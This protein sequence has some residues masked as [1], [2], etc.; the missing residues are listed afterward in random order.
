MKYLGVRVDQYLNWEGHLLTRW[1]K[2]NIHPYHL[3]NL[4]PLFSLNIF[5]ARTLSDMSLGMPVT[6]FVQ[7]ILHFAD[8]FI[9]GNWP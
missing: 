7:T 9:T 8:F 6:Y 3:L 1:T 5:F 2:E 4:S